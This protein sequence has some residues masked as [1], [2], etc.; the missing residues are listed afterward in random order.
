[1]AA[2]DSKHPAPVQHEPLGARLVLLA[3]VTGGLGVV[4][5]N[6]IVRTM[7]LEVERTLPFVVLAIGAALMGVGCAALSEVM[8]QT[9]MTVQQAWERGGNHMVRALAWGACTP[10][11]FLGVVPI[12]AAAIIVAGVFSGSPFAVVF[13]MLIIPA[14]GAMMRV[15]VGYTS[16]RFTSPKDSLIVEALVVG[17]IWG[18]VILLG[19]PVLS[20]LVLV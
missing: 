15:L 12:P 7:G 6:I 17:A 5:H 2:H 11:V 10:I 19:G 9:Q 3:F 4:L 20:D 13:G 8:R 16:A 18:A 14:F 1:M